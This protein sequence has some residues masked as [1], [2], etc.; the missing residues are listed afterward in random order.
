M[1][2]SHDKLIVARGF[3]ASVSHIPPIKDT[4]IGSFT[5]TEAQVY[6]WSLSYRLSLQESALF[7]NCLAEVISSQALQLAVSNSL[8]ITLFGKDLITLHHR[9]HTPGSRKS[10]MG[11]EITLAISIRDDDGTWPPSPSRIQNVLQDTATRDKQRS[12]EHVI[13]RAAEDHCESQKL[14]TIL[15][16]QQHIKLANS[17]H[18]GHQKNGFGR[19]RIVWLEGSVEVVIDL[20][21]RT[22]TWIWGPRTPGRSSLAAELVDLIGEQPHLF[23]MRLNG[24]SWKTREADW[25]P[26]GPINVGKLEIKLRSDGS[27]M[28]DENEEY[29]ELY[30]FSVD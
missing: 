12:S 17:K 26:R 21:E 7:R 3:L 9:M 30:R 4:I 8:R 16:W 6:T 28:L 10:H 15:L 11:K 23:Y 24:K 18:E 13:L 19:Y 27:Y 5:P 29:T 25:S 2:E 22:Q 14:L 1:L 20:R